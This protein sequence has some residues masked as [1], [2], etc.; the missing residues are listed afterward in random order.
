MAAAGGRIPFKSGPGQ[1]TPAH[2]TVGLVLGGARSGKSRFAQQTALALAGPPFAD[3][4]I[5]VA[6]SRRW[7]DD[8][9]ARI[10]RHQRDRGPEWRNVE[11]EKQL[12]RTAVAGDVAVV[13]CVTLWL[14]NFFIDHEQNVE[15]VLELARPE[16]ERAAAIDAHWIFVS[17]EL[18][19]GPHAMTESGRKFTDLQ[20]FVNQHIAA[21]ADW[22]V[23]MVAGIP[24]AVKGT[25]PRRNA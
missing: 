18:G 3:R 2:V 13:D 23:M 9:A 1:T 11:E 19:L 10:A 12:S 22:V 15:R 6:T 21:R 14:T 7:D 4:P 20:G 24:L 8:H 5:Y 16:F 25:A 17:N